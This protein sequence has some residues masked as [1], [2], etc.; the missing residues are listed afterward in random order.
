MKIENLNIHSSN[1]VIAEKII[2]SHS[3]NSWGID[4]NE[5]K[6]LFATIKEKEIPI[7]DF[8]RSN[9][10]REDIA[11]LSPDKKDKFIGGLKKFGFEF[12]TKLS[13]AGIVE[14]LKYFLFPVSG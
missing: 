10:D 6:Q 7:N 5:L 14:L 1:V 2:N 11:S 3:I 12:A 9:F 8:I 4:E 13:S